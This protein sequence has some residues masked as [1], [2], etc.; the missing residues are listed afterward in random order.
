MKCLGKSCRERRPVVR[1]VAAWRDRSDD[2]VIQLFAC[3]GLQGFAPDFLLLLGDKHGGVTARQPPHGDVERTVSDDPDRE[4]LFELIES[5]N[6][7]AFG[8]TG[9]AVRP[10]C[11]V[12]MHDAL[13][14][15]F[16]RERVRP[17]R[18]P[19][20]RSPFLMANHT[21]VSNS[22]QFLSAT[23]IRP[24]SDSDARSSSK[25]RMPSANADSASSSRPHDDIGLCQLHGIAASES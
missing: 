10:A 17:S 11:V 20:S 5:Y 21:P 6:R 4:L 7:V 19:G 23:E 24:S 8:S 13:R 16:A 18:M 14:L 1:F 2:L 12:A 3:H 15:V 9:P 25:A 22:S